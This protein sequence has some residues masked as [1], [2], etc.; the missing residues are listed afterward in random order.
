MSKNISINKLSILLVFSCISC[1]NTSKS[2]V[3]H[4][5][6]IDQERSIKISGLDVAVIQDIARDSA[7]ANW[8]GLMPVYKMPADTDMKNYQPMQPGTYHIADGA[9]IFTPD[10]P[11]VSHR[12]YFVRYYKLDSDNQLTDFIGGRNRPGSLHYIDLTF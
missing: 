2:P 8:Q 1:S 9:V 7:G 4:I 10:T 12:T 3:I 6:K 11:F 5:D